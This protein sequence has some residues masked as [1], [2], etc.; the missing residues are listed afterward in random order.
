V[1]ELEPQALA[2][3]V[4][5]ALGVIDAILK[6]TGLPEPSAEESEALGLA[7][8][9]P[10]LRYRVAK[11]VIEQA[12]GKPKQQ[13]EI[14]HDFNPTVLMLPSF[15]SDEAALAAASVGPVLELEAGDDEEEARDG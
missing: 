5:S 10:E 13:V 2:A 11:D 4:P 1:S 7:D 3:R 12:Y 9:D 6:G 8:F 14:E 15:V